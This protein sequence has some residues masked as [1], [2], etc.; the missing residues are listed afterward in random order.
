V[1]PSQ[2]IG[3]Q[4]VQPQPAPE[5]W[6]YRVLP[7]G[8]VL[9]QIHHVGG[10]HVSFLPP[11][12]AVAIGEEIAKLGRQG[13]TGIIQVTSIPPHLPNGNGAG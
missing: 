9:V 7:D 12:N 4:I 1:Q 8:N 6:D 13:K 10:V 2:P 3:P 5:T 11:N